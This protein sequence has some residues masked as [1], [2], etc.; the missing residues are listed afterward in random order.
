MF[1]DFWA[2]KGDPKTLPK[3]VQSLTEATHG[4]HPVPFWSF[5]RPHLDFEVILGPFW[6]SPG[7]FFEEYASFFDHVFD[8]IFSS[9]LPFFSVFLGICGG[10]GGLMLLVILVLLVG[11]WVE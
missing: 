6:A 5:Q 11:G 3:A 10:S 9:W 8:A 2:P 1:C 7:P 4:R